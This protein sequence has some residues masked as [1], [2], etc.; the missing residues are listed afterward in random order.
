MSILYSHV[1]QRRKVISDLVS[2]SALD[3]LIEKITDFKDMIVAIR[4]DEEEY[5]YNMPGHMK[6][7]FAATEAQEA[8]DT[9]E[10]AMDA[11]E[12]AAYQLAEALYE[13]GELME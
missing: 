8:M 11:A 1:I 4:S 6:D 3:S 5:L 12:V 7:G 9:M 2:T 13:L 10:R